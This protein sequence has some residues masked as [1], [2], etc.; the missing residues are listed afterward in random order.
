MDLSVKMTEQ[1][2][3]LF[4]ERF[5]KDKG[6]C[7]T[8]YQEL[9]YYNTF[10]RP[11]G[12]GRQFTFED[13]M[14]FRERFGFNSIHTVIPGEA[15][16]LFP[17]AE[18]LLNELNEI[19][20]ELKKLSDEELDELVKMFDEYYEKEN[21]KESEE[22]KNLLN[23]DNWLTRNLVKPG[24]RAFESTADG[25]WDGTKYIGRVMA[26]DGETVADAFN[27][28]GSK[29]WDAIGKEMCTHVASGAAVAMDLSVEVKNGSVQILKIVCSDDFPVIG[30][31]SG[32]GGDMAEGLIKLISGDLSG[33]KQF[34]DGNVRVMMYIVADV[35]APIYGNTVGKVE[36][37]KSAI[38]SSETGIRKYLL[39]II[40]PD[41]GNYAGANW[42]ADQMKEDELIDKKTKK[43]KY[44]EYKPYMGFNS[45]IEHAS[46][47]HDYNTDNRN[48][49][50]PPREKA[51]M[52]WIKNVWTTKG[53]EPGPVGQH[54]RILGTIAFLIASVIDK[55]KERNDYK[56]K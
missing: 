44:E 29:L 9:I 19:G 40:I 27:F 11:P 20:N 30:W 55:G 8:P 37:M 52:Q 6:I 26:D 49:N 14:R 36:G 16:M 38:K 42:G 53:V 54:Y 28:V 5:V 31:A 41:Y 34:G 12:P 21:K 45:R 39:P 10:V 50:K 22:T 4:Y 23:D 51:H 1:E 24:L 17:E 32:P 7:L 15:I 46:F 33:L 2:N 25:I 47:I 56:K 13:E 43:L 35:T 18:N 3:A 48:K